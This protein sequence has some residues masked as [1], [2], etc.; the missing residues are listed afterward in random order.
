MHEWI[1]TMSAE[2]SPQTTVESWF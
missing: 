1:K 2:A